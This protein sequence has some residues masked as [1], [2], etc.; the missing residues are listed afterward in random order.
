MEKLQLLGIREQ[1]SLFRNFPLNLPALVF[2][3]TS[4]L[5]LRKRAQYITLNTFHCGFLNTTHFK[6]IC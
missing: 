4:L 2:F 3:R 5:N 6:V 1:F